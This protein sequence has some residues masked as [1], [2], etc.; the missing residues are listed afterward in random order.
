[1]LD[2]II[3]LDDMDDDDIEEK[4]ITSKIATPKHGAGGINRNFGGLPKQNVRTIKHS[5]NV[6]GIGTGTSIRY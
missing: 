6:S 5:H 2:P 4:P 1:M 3:F